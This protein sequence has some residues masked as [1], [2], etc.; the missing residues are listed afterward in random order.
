[1]DTLLGSIKDSFVCC[2]DRSKDS[3]RPKGSQ[4]QL[5]DKS[6]AHQSAPLLQL[7]PL[8][9]SSP[10]LPDRS[11]CISEEDVETQKRLSA[12]TLK[13]H[14]NVRGNRPGLVGYSIQDTNDWRQLSGGSSAST[15]PS[16]GDINRVHRRQHATLLP[17]SSQQAVPIKTEFFEGRALF[18]HRESDPSMP[19]Q[20][21][22]EKRRRN[23]ECRVQGRFKRKPTGK[24][25][26]GVV[27]RDFNYNQP[28]AG[29]SKLVRTAGMKLV[30]FESYLSW[31]D[32]CKDAELPDAELACMV[33]DLAGWDQIIV[34]RPGEEVPDIHGRLDGLGLVRESMG[35]KPYKKAAEQLMKDLETEYTYTF[36][37]WG[38]SRVV[39]MTRWQFNFSMAMKVSMDTFFTGNPLH[40]C[41]YELCVPPESAQDGKE[42]RHLESMKRYYMDFLFFPNYM[43]MDHLVDKYNFKDADGS[44]CCPDEAAPPASD[45]HPAAAMQERK[46]A[47]LGGF[48]NARSP[49]P[50]AR[51]PT[52]VKQGGGF[53]ACLAQ[54]ASMACGRGEASRPRELTVGE[55][56]R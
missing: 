20:W 53:A 42:V 24:L 17:Q 43:T 22:F 15:A 44:P 37:F 36:S 41:M 10:L 3:K 2:A 56:P 54:A 6:G 34:T 13:A 7:S 30:P 48:P 27:L 11:K 16:E 40:G 26:V 47:A 49:P 25:F 9:Q 28:V 33:S 5:L 8:L 35:I 38:C 55:P 51:K 14:R 4:P 18:M 39:D 45:L 52:A 46:L 1:M 31:G 19:H 50:S 21:H 12:W 29:P 23:W 32:R